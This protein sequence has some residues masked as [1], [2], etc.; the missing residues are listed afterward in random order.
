MNWILPPGASTY[1]GDIDFLYYLILVITG[2]AFVVVEVALVWFMIK[3][4][5]RP[6]RK[7]Y[8]TQG[9][10]TAEIIWTAVPAV[11]VVAIGILSGRVWNDIRGRDSIP[12]GAYPIAVQA[13]QFE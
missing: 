7:A 11:V 8:Y 6:G 12:A 3:Y 1:A 10:T 13:K 9:S 2:I 4:R 5:A